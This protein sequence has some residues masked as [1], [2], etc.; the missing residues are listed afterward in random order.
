MAQDILA[1]ADR[2]AHGSVGKQA[3]QLK[4]VLGVR[5]GLDPFVYENADFLPMPKMAHHPPRGEKLQTSCE[6]A[7]GLLPMLPGIEMPDEYLREV[8]RIA[9]QRA[10][11][12]QNP[13]LTFEMFSAVVMWTFDAVLVSE[14]SKQTKE[15]SFYY[16]MN[17]HVD[18]RDAEFFYAARGY[19][20]YFMTALDYLPPAEGIVYQG[21]PREHAE[22]VRELFL[23]G[24]ILVWRS[25][26]TALQLWGNLV[27]YERGLILQIT[28]LPRELRAKGIKYESKGRDIS[29]LSAITGS[30]EV[31]LLPNIRLRVGHE[32]VK[33]GIP[34]IELREMEED[35][36]STLNAEDFD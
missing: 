34:V 18:Q 32:T 2:I 12:V 20:Y 35:T 1:S 30:S 13:D 7:Q 31:L 9:A 25:F 4:T 8:E 23:P 17:Q 11:V 29:K 10:E 24:E 15:Q 6:Y 19:F 16:L 21:I 36:A 27:M 26:T 22:R 5:A 33:K 3:K 28:L 14:D